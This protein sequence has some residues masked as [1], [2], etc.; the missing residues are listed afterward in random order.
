MTDRLDYEWFAVFPSI[1]LLSLDRN[2]MVLWRSC[3]YAIC[4]NMT[5]GLYAVI[6]SCQPVLMCSL[7][8]A[9]AQQTPPTPPC[10][11][12]QENILTF[13]C[14]AMVID[15]ILVITQRMLLKKFSC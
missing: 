8:L 14:F 3:Q 10:P 5:G 9:F 6:V 12:W 1:Y 7:N 15:I 13:G 11:N 2:I 4:L